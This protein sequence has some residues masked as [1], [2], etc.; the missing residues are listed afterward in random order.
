MSSASRRALLMG[1]VLAALPPLSA[2]W[3]RVAQAQHA[4]DPWARET[5]ENNARSVSVRS[6]LNGRT[7]WQPRQPRRLMPG[8]AEQDSVKP[9]QDVR[10]T[11]WPV[12]ASAVLPG[13]GQALRRERRALAY[14]AIEAFALSNFA[15]HRRVAR[16]TRDGYRTLAANVARAPFSTE[17][18]TG[19]FDYYERMKSFLA[20]GR[21]DLSDGARPIEPEIDTTTF[22]GATWLLARRTYWTDPAQPPPRGSVEWARAEAFYLQRAVRPS[23]RWSWEG[24]PT[25]YDR[26][27]TLIQRS[28]DRSRAALSNLGLV[29]GNHVLS[30]IDASIAVRLDRRPSLA[31]PEYVMT[32]ELPLDL[33]R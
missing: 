14:L 23:F 16:R 25:E 3:A 4:S 8:G 19:D 20:S 17:R 18:P 28:N 29:L 7:P 10:S 21:F 13:A 31:G 26:F 24:A 9:G 12:L 27:R 5:R 32:F 6:V 15:S 33:G 2:G 11:A 30:A 22:N 1:G